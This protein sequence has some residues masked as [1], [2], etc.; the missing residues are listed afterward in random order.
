MIL[1]IISVFVILGIVYVPFLGVGKSA[2]QSF[3]NEFE[4]PRSSSASLDAANLG[5]I[6]KPD[7]SYVVYS[8]YSVSLPPQPHIP[9]PTVQAWSESMGNMASAATPSAH[10]GDKS[11]ETDEKG[12]TATTTVTL[13]PL[14]ILR[15]PPRLSP[16]SGTVVVGQNTIRL[17]NQDTINHTIVIHYYSVVNNSFLFRTT[18]VTLGPR[19]SWYI[20][21]IHVGTIQFLDFQDPGVTSTIVIQQVS[22][23]VKDANVV[24]FVWASG[25]LSD[26]VLS[27]EAT[28]ISSNSRWRA[29]AP[30]FAIYEVKSSIRNPKSSI[31]N[32]SSLVSPHSYVLSVY[33]R[34]ARPSS[35]SPGSINSFWPGYVLTPS[36]YGGFLVLENSMGE[37][38]SI[39]APASPS[40]IE[41]YILYLSDNG[42]LILKDSVSQVIWNSSLSSISSPT[43]RDFF[44]PDDFTQELADFEDYEVMR[45]LG[46]DFTQLFH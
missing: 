43:K 42:D 34:P 40:F 15:D 35:N 19:Q 4:Q 16:S 45:A 31:A 37:I 20:T 25:F 30:C 5:Y 29:S 3:T 39:G 13:Y 9:N 26:S 1:F 7:A 24:P 38:K 46:G 8:Q 36:I 28:L 14:V 22:L 10:I 12:P 21:P 17:L 11:F 33:K 18:E 32:C 2:Y 27:A 23:N 6:A 44:D 41:P